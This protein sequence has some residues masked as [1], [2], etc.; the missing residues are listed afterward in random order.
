MTL[1]VPVDVLV[2][3]IYWLYPQLAGDASYDP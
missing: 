2:H 3:K 1:L